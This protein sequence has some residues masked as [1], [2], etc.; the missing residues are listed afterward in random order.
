MTTETENRLSTTVK[1]AEDKTQEMI[2][3]AQEKMGEIT[4]MT[5]EER[6]KA[7]VKN[8]EGK[9]QEMLGEITGNPQD[10][11][12]GQVKQNEARAEHIVENAKE[13][14]KKTIN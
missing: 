12:E 5:T 2:G 6:V 8:I 11:A 13:E 3:E 7:T 4:S 14:A 10:K 1:N 9:A